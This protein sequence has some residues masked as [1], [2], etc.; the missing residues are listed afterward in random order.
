M[1]SAYLRG[2]DSIRSRYLFKGVLCHASHTV[3]NSSAAFQGY[4]SPI[5]FF[6]NVPQIFY[7]I[8]VRRLSWPRHKPNL[9]NSNKFTG[10]F[11]GNIALESCWNIYFSCIFHSSITSFK[12]PTQTYPIHYTSNWVYL[13]YTIIRKAS[14]YQQLCTTMFHCLLYIPSFIFG[15]GRLSNTLS[16]PSAI[17]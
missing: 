9:I 12:M 10:Q 8:Q 2:I 1:T 17:K 15:V 5:H 7:G 16:R 11:I 6:N 4:F 14:S 3:M 13:A